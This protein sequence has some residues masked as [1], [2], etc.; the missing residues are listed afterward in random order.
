MVVCLSSS[1][2][3][4]MEEICSSETSGLGELQGIATY[5]TVL[6]NEIQVLR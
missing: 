5:K 3:L 4:K 6:F 2:V 1:S